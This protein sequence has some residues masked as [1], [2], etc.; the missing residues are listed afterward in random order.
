[1]DILDHIA[2]IQ[3]QLDQIQAKQ[4]EITILLQKNNTGSDFVTAEEAAH[5]LGFPVTPSGHHK[6]R[7]KKV[8]QKYGLSI[9]NSIPHRYKKTEI[10]RLMD[11]DLLID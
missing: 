8:R 10:E 11:C 6:R 9:T 4:N 3:A 5:M 2:R 7:L 1:M